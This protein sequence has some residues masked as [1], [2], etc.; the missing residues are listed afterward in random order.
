MNLTSKISGAYIML[1]AFTS[2]RKLMDISQRKE[3]F[4]KAYIRAVASAAGY[5]VSGPSVDDDGVDLVFGSRSKHG[6]V[7]S[8]KLEAQVKCTSQDILKESSLNFPLEIKNY[9]LLIQEDF[10]VPR[11]LIVVIVPEDLDQWLAHEEK[12][13]LVRYCGYWMSLKGLP[14][15]NNADTITVAIPRLNIFDTS[16]LHNLMEK[17]AEGKD[18]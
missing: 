15:T 12:G 16:T 17:I 10:L 13:L 4:S 8:P 18:L 11:I 2:K 7:K 14:Q 3:Q 5:D 1:Q 6:S 9:N